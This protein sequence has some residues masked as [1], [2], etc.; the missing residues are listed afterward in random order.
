[1]VKHNQIVVVEPA[2]FAFAGAGVEYVSVLWSTVREVTAYKLDLI[3]TDEVRLRLEL[4]ISPFSVEVAEEMEGFESF[5]SAAERYF[6][7]PEGWWSQV[8]QP[9]FVTNAH[10]LFRRD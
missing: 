1:M 5:K 7:F 8:I 10:V 9:A 3:T 4:D 6:Q 2:G